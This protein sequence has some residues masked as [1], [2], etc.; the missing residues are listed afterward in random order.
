[1][2][3]KNILGPCG[4]KVGYWETVEPKRLDEKQAVKTT[5]RWLIREEDGAK[6]FS[7]RL[8]EVEPEGHIRAHYHPWEHEIYVLDGVGE[9]RIGSRVYRVTKGFFIYIPPNVEHEYW[10]K[11]NDKTLRFLCIIPN[12]PTVDDKK[13]KEC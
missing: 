12:K 5:V 8:F 13:K 11:S 1:M 9:I 2:E 4:E 6:T 10:N 7:M 3:K